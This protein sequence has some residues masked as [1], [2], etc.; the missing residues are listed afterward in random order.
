MQEKRRF[1]RLLSVLVVLLSVLTVMVC[2]LL[3]TDTKTRYIKREQDEVRAYYTGLYCSNTG[4]DR[5][6]ALENGVGY[7]DFQIMNY[8]GEDVTKRD[9]TYNIETLNT[10]YDKNGNEIVDKNSNGSNIDELKNA[11]NLYVKNVWNEPQL[12][13][14]DSY[15]YNVSITKNDGDT[16]KET[17]NG[18][19][20]SF[21]KFPY[22]ERDESAVGIIHN[23]TVKIERKADSVVG[24]MSGT[25]ESV[26]LVI[27]LDKP[28]KE[29]YIVDIVISNR[30]I[31]FST[32]QVS[33]FEI[34]IFK[35]QTQTFDIFAY[36]SKGNANKNE[37]STAL[38][39][40]PF[41]VVYTWK[42][43]IVNE[44]NFKF[45][46][47]NQLDVL[48]GVAD[49]IDISKP[50]VV[51]INQTKDSG[52]IEMYIPQSSNFIFDFLPTNTNYYIYAT[53]YIY[54]QSTSS[55]VPYDFATWGGYT[56]KIDEANPNAGGTA[57]LAYIYNK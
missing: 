2:S 57:G 48:G 55:Y 23:V 25:T 15:K 43:V 9:I 56:D 16:H 36:D 13:C 42:N 38:A 52:T 53:V 18:S 24:E 34:D 12:I 21:Y 8:I 45:F 49:G 35:V 37:D 10:F 1:F 27:Q 22:I 41:K 44:N 26:S 39:S 17:I 11:E 46:H 14:K 33:E 5:A 54:D 3:V 51:S 47:N 4:G 19:E 31:V 7:V 50:Y 20:K 29:V 6:V 28:Y 30:L 40:R 32:R